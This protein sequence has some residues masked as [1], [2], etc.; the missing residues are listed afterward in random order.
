MRL[1]MGLARRRP[2][3]RGM[4][5]T[6]TLVAVGLASAALSGCSLVGWGYGQ[7][8]ALAQW[9]LQRQLPLNEAQ[10]TRLGSDLEAWHTW[11]RQTQL[12]AITT[13][14]RHWQALA[15]GPV[16]ADTLCREWA[17]VRQHLDQAARQAVPALARL[18]LTLDDAQLAALSASQQ[19]SHDEY[20]A[21]HAERTGGW[22]GWGLQPAQASVPASG[23]APESA[24]TTAS[25]LHRQD[26]ARQRYERL[27]GPLSEMQ[28]EALAATLRVSAFDP[29]RMLAERQRRSDD[30]VASLRIARKAAGLSAE[31]ALHGW[32]DRLAQSPT[33][34]HDAWTRR[35]TREGCEQFAAVHNLASSDQRLQA[36]RTLAGYEADLR[37]AAGR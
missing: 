21:Q 14:L 22:L 7:L 36:Q 24:S 26:T 2:M 23:P 33:P 10:R 4:N 29:G 15:A 30:L 5:T 32:L 6:S 11:H 20:R 8:P 28:M 13:R 16:D 27:Y 9:W 17:V 31:Q 18:A 1:R 37:R 19:A 3:I 25:L 12:V 34:G 35:L